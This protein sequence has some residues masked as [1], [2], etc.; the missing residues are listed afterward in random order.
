MNKTKKNIVGSAGFSLIEILLVL[1][2]STIVFSI[3]VQILILPM[4]NK[5]IINPQV[6]FNNADAGL[7]GT[8]TF[9]ADRGVQVFWQSNAFSEPPIFEFNP[10]DSLGKRFCAIDNIVQ[11]KNIFIPP[12][13]KSLIT[14]HGV[15]TGMRSIGNFLFLSA[16]SATSSDPDLYLF[17]SVNEMDPQLI[18]SLNTGPGLAGMLIQGHYLFLANTSVNAQFQAVDISAI[19][20][21]GSPFQLKLMAELKIPGS[22]SSSTKL[23]PVINSISSDNSGNIYLG[24]QKSDLGE[25]FI[26][27]FNGKQFSFKK[28]YDNGGIV[29]DIFANSAG[30]YGT[31]PSQELFHYNPLGIVDFVYD[32]PGLAGNGN[33]IDLLGENL[34]MLGRTIGNQELIQING[35]MEKIGNSIEDIVINVD[36]TGNIFVI[37]L[38]TISSTQSELQI[39]DTIADYKIGDI[40]GGL[41]GA[42][43][44]QGIIEKIVFNKKTN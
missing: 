35:P 7:M 4:F 30:W 34:I 8:S 17:N 38:A 42:T 21:T 44:T 36:S 32:A 11:N 26:A 25:I 23:N 27:N 1:G 22:K 43:G 19:K 6:F 5:N 3:F 40:G 2:L 12:T 33:R 13:I 10:D 37:V 24:S 39:W 20:N 18:S 31:S 29:N 15:A 28:S 16:N 9:T 14:S 41:N